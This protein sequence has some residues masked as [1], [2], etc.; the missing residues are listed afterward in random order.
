MARRGIST[1]ALTSLK[2]AAG[3]WA[4]G[5][6]GPAAPLETLKALLVDDH[7]PRRD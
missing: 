5:A 4:A 6:G 7:R 3:P 2:S 1:R